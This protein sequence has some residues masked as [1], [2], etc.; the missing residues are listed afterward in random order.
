MNKLEQ[1]KLLED[2][3]E[4]IDNRLDELCEVCELEALMQEY[5]DE[6][7]DEIEELQ[8]KYQETLERLKELENE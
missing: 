2:I 1:K 7:S 5:T 8:I 4:S 3:L 6:T